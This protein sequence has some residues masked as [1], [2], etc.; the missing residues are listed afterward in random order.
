M[1]HRYRQPTHEVDG[2][3]A[4]SPYNSWVDRL[5]GVNAYEPG[6]TAGSTAD[7]EGIYDL[8]VPTH[9]TELSVLGDGPAFGLLCTDQDKDRRHELG[10]SV[11]PVGFSTEM[12][13][14]LWDALTTS[15]FDI[16]GDYE[17]SWLLDACDEA[18]SDQRYRQHASYE[19]TEEDRRPLS[20]NTWDWDLY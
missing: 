9:G 15:K 18:N 20:D 13:G 1:S 17:E 8:S 6:L 7:T 2:L 16:E 5:F 10:F 14:D 12:F 11:G 4:E 3:P 19:P